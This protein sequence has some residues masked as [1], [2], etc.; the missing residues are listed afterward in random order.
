M[1][2]ASKNRNSLTGVLERSCGL[3][4]RRKFVILG[5]MWPLRSSRISMM[6]FSRISE[7]FFTKIL[8]VFLQA[9]ATRPPWIV[10]KLASISST[11]KSWGRGLKLAKNKKKHKYKYHYLYFK[12]CTTYLIECK[13][14]SKLLT[15]WHCSRLKWSPTA[16]SWPPDFEDVDCAHFETNFLA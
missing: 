10:S 6:W 5:A 15:T 11:P 16:S 12:H 8:I 3:A 9:S 13:T 14:N 7:E 2:L 4:S 1:R